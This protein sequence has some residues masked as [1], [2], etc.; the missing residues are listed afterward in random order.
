MPQLGFCTHKTLKE[1]GSDATE[2]MDLPVRVRADRQRA[3]SFF[4]HVLYLKVWPRLKEGLHIS[5][6]FR[7]KNPSQVCPTTQS[8]VNSRCSQVENQARPSH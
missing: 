4:S 1:V 2:G 6:D 5:N 7:K 3:K 8:L